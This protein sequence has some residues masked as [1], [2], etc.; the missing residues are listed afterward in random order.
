MTQPPKIL[1]IEDDPA[2]GKLIE[3]MLTHAG[4]RVL[5]ANRGLLGIDIARSEFPDLILTDI[6]LPDMSGYEVATALRAEERFAGV[7]IVA[8]T[9]LG[10]GAQDMAMAAGITGF[11]SKPVDIEQLI[12]QIQYY[13]QGGQDTIDSERLFSAQVKYTREVVSR[14]EGRIRALEEANDALKKLDNMKET[15]IQVTAHELR[16]PLTLIYGYS[17]LLEDHPT[18]NKMAEYDQSVKMLV[19][20]LSDS[21]ARMQRVIE[22][23][24]IISRIMTKQIDLALSPTNLSQLVARVLESYEEAFEQR[25]LT[26]HFDPAQWPR[27]TQLDSE[28]IRI[29]MSNLISNAIKYTPDGGQIYLRAQTT[30]DQVMFSVRDTGIGIDVENQK[31]IFEQFGSLGDVKLHSTSKTAFGG[32][33]L[34]L[35]LPVCK[36]IVEAH[37]GKIWVESQGR[38]PETCPGSQFIVTLPLVVQRPRPMLTRLSK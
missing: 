3:R 13:L 33:G 6:N 19:E 38:D 37:G 28:L 11:L 30:S 10:P 24:L 29:V 16:T 14:L 4:Y 27:Q 1:Y 32:G 21:I 9:A 12:T 15:F 17:R 23:I 7:P 8:L 25:K 34:G 35:G 20:S 18:V 26:V 2:S 5:L 31:R 22:E 36:G